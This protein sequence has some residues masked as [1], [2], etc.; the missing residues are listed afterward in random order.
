MTMLPIE[1]TKKLGLV[2]DLD[3]CG[4]SCLCGEL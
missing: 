3:I 2:I 1:P 4:L